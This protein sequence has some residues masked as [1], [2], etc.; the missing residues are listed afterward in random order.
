MQ[1]I[2]QELI[3]IHQIIKRKI[4]LNLFKIIMMKRKDK[5]NKLTVNIRLENKMN[6]NGILLLEILIKKQIQTEIK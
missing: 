1:L 5:Q 4:K 6:K 3:R 2:N